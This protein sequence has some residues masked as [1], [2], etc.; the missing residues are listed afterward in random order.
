V[1]GSLSY[2]VL[3]NKSQISISEEEFLPMCWNGPVGG[4]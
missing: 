3:L 1:T 4:R 2:Y